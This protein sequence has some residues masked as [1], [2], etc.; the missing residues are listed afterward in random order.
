MEIFGFIANNWPVILR[1]AGEHISIVAVAVGLAI[2]TGVPIGIAIT[3][4]RRVADG[5]LYVARSSS[6][7]P[8]S[9]FS[10]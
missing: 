3:Q 7:S 8:R 2:L 1:L 4:N 9:R 5:V 6:R 10:A